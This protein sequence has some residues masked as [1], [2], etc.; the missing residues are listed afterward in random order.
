MC[1]KHLALFF[2]AVL[3]GLVFLLNFPPAQA[4]SVSA[5]ELSAVVGTSEASWFAGEIYT[6]TPSHIDLMGLGAA[7][8]GIAVDSRVVAADRLAS[9][10]GNGSGNGLYAYT[11]PTA[12]VLDQGISWHNY[13][14]CH[15]KRLS[16]CNNFKSYQVTWHCGCRAEHGHQVPEPGS[17]A[18]LGAGLLLL[19]AHRSRASQR[20]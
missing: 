3:C 19:L 5:W 20:T 14:P 9:A 10:P 6:G 17:L 1:I 12:S 15:T 11:S 7:D 16:L 2:R 4:R 8:G 13:S 18:L